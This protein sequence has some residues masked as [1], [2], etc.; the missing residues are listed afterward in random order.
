MSIFESSK[1]SPASGALY[2]FLCEDGVAPW[3]LALHVIKCELEFE[4]KSCKK[5]L[6]FEDQ[7][8]QFLQEFSFRKALGSFHDYF[9]DMWGSVDNKGKY[10]APTKRAKRFAKTCPPEENNDANDTRFMGEYCRL[11]QSGVEA[12]YFQLPLSFCHE[13]LFFKYREDSVSNAEKR[14]LIWGFSCGKS[15]LGTARRNFEVAK[16]KFGK[17]AL[18]LEISS[19]FEEIGT[20]I[21]RTHVHRNPV[22]NGR[23]S[24]DLASR[25]HRALGL[26]A[27]TPRDIHKGQRFVIPDTLL[28]YTLS[29]IEIGKTLKSSP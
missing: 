8:E 23:L 4:E 22:R 20:V 12:G 3:I 21:S 2:D 25:I 6:D 16:S 29:L 27:P 18:R 14:E 26:V 7:E 5:C 1:N 15:L 10:K 28:T 11:L 24:R 13:K 19:K 9:E 17:H